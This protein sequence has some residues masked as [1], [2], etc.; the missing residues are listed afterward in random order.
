MLCH[1]K[2]SQLHDQSRW[3]LV[4]RRAVGDP[5]LPRGTPLGRYV[6]VDRIGSG[7]MSVVYSAYD[8]ELDRKIAVKLLRSEHWGSDGQARALREAQALARLAHPNVVVIHDVGTVGAQLFMAMELVPGATLREWLGQTPRSWREIVAL[9]IQAGRGLAAAHAAGLVHRD[10]KPG[11]IL[12]DASGRARVSDFGVV[13]AANA[14]EL[15]E[16]E[17]E[18]PRA[19]GPTDPSAGTSPPASAFPRMRPSGTT[20]SCSNANIFPVRPRPT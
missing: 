13:V 3:H 9:M 17:A 11:N 14:D 16:H 7:G 8:P 2:T 4:L 15:R 5:V 20:F 12:V 1:H 18:P 10:V 19:G 6:I